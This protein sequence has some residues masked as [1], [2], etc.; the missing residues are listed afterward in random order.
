MT[1]ET[2]WIAFDEPSYVNKLAKP[3]VTLSRVKKFCV[4]A[5]AFKRLGSPNA[6]L[7]FFDVRRNL[8]GIRAASPTTPHAVHVIRCSRDRN[9]GY[10][11]G[12]P[13]CNKFRIHL[14]HTIEF[15]EV[16]FERDGTMILD[17]NTARRF[18]R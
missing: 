8:I 15:N 4:G 3:R 13:F 1:I 12:G 17:L 9:I 6:V 10:I 14:D 5:K 18:A 7:L 16:Q 11:S 2:E